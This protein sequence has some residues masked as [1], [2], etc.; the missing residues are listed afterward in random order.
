MTSVVDIVFGIKANIS[1]VKHFS[2]IKM[3]KLLLT[4]LSITAAVSGQ[5]TELIP[6]L[7]QFPW[8]VAIT[9]HHKEFF[10]KCTG[11]LI[12]EDWILT[13]ALLCGDDYPTSF[14]VQLGKVNFTIN[15]LI[16]DIPRENYIFHPEYFHYENNIALLKLPNSIEITEFVNFIN[17]PEWGSGDFVGVTALYGGTVSNR[18]DYISFN[19]SKKIIKFFLK[20]TYYLSTIRYNFLEVISD[21]ECLEQTTLQDG[22]FCTIGGTNNPEKYPCNLDRG[23]S[24]A[25]DIDGNFTIIGLTANGGCNTNNPVLFTR[26]SLYLDWINEVFFFFYLQHYPYKIKSKSPHFS[27]SVYLIRFNWNRSSKLPSIVHTSY[28][29]YLY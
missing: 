16:S 13:T 24:L 22:E 8:I 17:L 6:E 14:S 1:P 11:A 19:E 23:S 4:I 3:L 25:I 12:S 5:N 18:G 27:M 26:V 20:A 7:G 21:E 15:E 28:S 9:A 29:V 10:R 2:F